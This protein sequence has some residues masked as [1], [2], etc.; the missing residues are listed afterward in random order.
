M[1]TRKLG[2]L[3]VSELG[4]GCMSISANYGPP[5]DRKRGIDV[6]RSAH[7]RGVTFFDKP[8]STAPTRTGNLSARRWPHTRQGQDSDE[9][10]LCD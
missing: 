3:E 5:A 10:R 4:S 9:V 8:R 2:S 1:K 6:I 7:E